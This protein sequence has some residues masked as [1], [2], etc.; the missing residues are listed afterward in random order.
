LSRRKKLQLF[1]FKLY[2]VMTQRDCFR[3]VFL[4]AYSISVFLRTCPAMDDAMATDPMDDKYVQKFKN[5][6]EQVDAFT[7]IAIKSHLI[8]ESAI[9]NIIRLIFFHP[10]IILDARVNFFQKVE[11]VRAYSLREDEMSIWKLMHAIAELRNE[12]AHNLEPKRREPRM[13]KVRTLFYSEVSAEIAKAHR[14][15]PDEMIVML[16]AGLCTGFLGSHERDLTGLRKQI[17]GIADA[18]LPRNPD[19]SIKKKP[20]KGFG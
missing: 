15:A 6:L 8:L 9:D 14:N 18:S 4:F 3:A 10:D 20:K 1:R 7:L 16:A 2:R 17:D 11:I 12:V 13:N 19:G 5:H